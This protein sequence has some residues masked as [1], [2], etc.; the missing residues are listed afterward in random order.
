VSKKQDTTIAEVPTSE[1]ATSN[2]SGITIAS[3]D[4]DVPRINVVQK[5][6][7]IEAPLGAVVLDKQHTLA[8]AD[9]PVPVTVLSVIKGWRE[10]ID[11]D[12]DEIPQIAYTQEEANQI[13]QN[14]E[15]DML[16]FAE[17]TLLF[18]Q[19]E[20]NDDEAAYPF[21]IGEENYAIGRINVAKD[22][23]RQTFKRLATFAA[24]NPKASLQ[25][26]VWEFRSSLISRG[27]YSWFAPSLGITQ[28]EPTEAVKTFVESFA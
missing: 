19:P 1:L 17:I 23:Y 20:G 15:Y 24:F 10:N 4:I 12:S 26:R 25:H 27:K 28:D 6:S 2:A 7:D 13:D 3:S 8:E 22:A 9:Q 14:S 18:R 11:Y 21:A 5:T 16:E